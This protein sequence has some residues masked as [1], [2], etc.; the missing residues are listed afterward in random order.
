MS[1]C[2]VLDVVLLEHLVIA[3]IILT[4]LGVKV[5]KIEYERKEACKGY[6]FVKGDIKYTNKNTLALILIGFSASFI[7]TTVGLG[8]GLVIQPLFIL[9]DLNAATASATGMYITMFTTG[10]ST[11][12]MIVI[13]RLDL[14]YTLIIN[15]ITIP[16]TLLGVYGQGWIVRKAKGRFQFTVMI[17]M[18]F[19]VFAVASIFPVMLKNLSSANDYGEDILEFSPYCT[20]TDPL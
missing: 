14:K 18:F 19:Q 15:I 2:D 8:V 13:Q 12:T 11:I 10:C 20:S 17:M 5:N 7:S 16:A 3:S 1:R 6:E 9:L 4:L